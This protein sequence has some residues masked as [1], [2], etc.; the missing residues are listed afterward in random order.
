M[1]SGQDTAFSMED[2]MD[3]LESIAY[4]IEDGFTPNQVVV[5]LERFMNDEA[6]FKPEICIPNIHSHPVSI[7]S[8]GGPIAAKD[9]FAK[10]FNRKNFTVDELRKGLEENAYMS[11]C[12]AAFDRSDTERMTLATMRTEN[13]GIRL[14]FNVVQE[15]NRKRVDDL[16]GRLIA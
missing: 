6:L 14:L 11:Q 15:K 13:K 3:I 9:M 2:G 8:H 7:I 1:Q 16:I 10:I 4:R 12:V 5:L